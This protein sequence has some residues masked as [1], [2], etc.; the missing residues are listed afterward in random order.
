MEN[1][2]E[3]QIFFKKELKSDD[4]QKYVVTKINALWFCCP[5]RS[6]D[7]A[8]Y[9]CSHTVQSQLYPNDGGGAS[10]MLQ[11]NSESCSMHCYAATAVWIRS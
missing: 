5:P 9:S 1:D 7:T 10:E 8:L 6:G 2:K 3:G 4:A 11:E